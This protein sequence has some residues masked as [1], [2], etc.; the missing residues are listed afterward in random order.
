MME[1]DYVIVGAGSAGCAIAYRLSE[2]GHS[3]IVIEHGGSDW[4]P[5]IQMPGALSFPMNMA[6]YDWGYRS[7]PEPNLGGRRMAVPRGKVIGGF[8]A[9]YE[10]VYSRQSIPPDQA[11]ADA[12]KQ[13]TASLDHDSTL[14]LE[15]LARDLADGGVPILWVTHDLAQVERIADHRVTLEAGRVAQA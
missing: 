10:F 5:F 14:A 12:Q 13:L 9:E 3:V 8:A 6:R 2:A 7:E 4:G 11:Y 15:R 1:A